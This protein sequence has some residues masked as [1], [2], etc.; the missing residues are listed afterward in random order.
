ML[1]GSGQNSFGFLRWVMATMVIVDH[2]FPLSGLR[3]GNDPTWIFS[4]GQ[5]SLGGI[6]VAGFFFISGFLVTGSQ[7]NSHGCARFLWKRFLR[8]FPGFWTCLLVTAFVFAPLAWIHE[9]GRL[10]ASFLHGPQSP[11]RYVWE[12]SLLHMHQYGID[13][14]MSSTPYG[15]VAGGAF[16]GS[17]WTLIYEFKCYLLIAVLAL[18]GLLWRRRWVLPVMTAPF[19]AL[20]VA[21]QVD[22]KWALHLAAPLNDVYVAR[23]GFLF[24]LG[25]TAAAYAP[26]LLLDDRLGLVALVGA[27]AALHWADWI[28]VGYPLF[29]YTLLWLAARLPMRWWG[30][31]GDLSYGLYI[32]SFPVQM[33]LA[34]HGMQKHGVAAFILVSIAV[35]SLPA[36]LSWHLIEKRA[37]RL[38]S[39]RLK[40]HRARTV[41][42]PPPKRDP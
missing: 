11:I 6:A 10:T 7:L 23:F 4:R 12:N 42:V 20:A 38:K 32:Y 33:L 5:D 13:G 15:R 18:S 1:G 25:A 35:T 31:M 3:G 26:R 16:D 34:D 39:F 9:R 36:Y 19:Y 29:G 14:L 40:R 41:Y 2:T 22:R 30:R 24:L 17:L 8:I 37:L 27:L 21:F 28:Q